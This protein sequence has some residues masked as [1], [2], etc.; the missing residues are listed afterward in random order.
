MRAPGWSRASLIE[1]DSTRDFGDVLE[2]STGEPS[3]GRGGGW[4][5][6]YAYGWPTDISDDDAL[7][8]LLALNLGN[9]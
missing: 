7:R 8:E 2:R 9:R 5:R 4:V 3:P 1:G 6:F